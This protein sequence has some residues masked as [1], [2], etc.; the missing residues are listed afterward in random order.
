MQFLYSQEHSLQ[1]YIFQFNVTVKGLFQG[2][3]GVFLSGQFCEFPSPIKY[4]PT[5]MH[6]MQVQ[7]TATSNSNNVYIFVS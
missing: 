6:K 4:N 5:V 1:N 3:N 2:Q 7:Q